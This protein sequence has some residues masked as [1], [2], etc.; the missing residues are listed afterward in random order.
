[1]RRDLPLG[2]TVE[3]YGTQVG[4]PGRVRHRR[5]GQLHRRGQAVESRERVT[6]TVRLR[7][8]WTFHD[9]TPVTA[10]SFV[11][12]WNCTAY[13]PNAQAGSYFFG[14]IEGYGDLQAPR[15]GEPTEP[16]AT[17]MSGLRSSTRR[18]SPSP[19]TAPFAQFPV[20]SATTRSSPCPRRSSRTRRRSAARRSATGRSRPTAS[21]SRR[22]RDGA[23]VR[24][25]G[26][27][28]PRRSRP[29]S[30]GSTP[31]PPPR[32][33]TRWPA[34]STSSR[35]SPPTRAVRPG[36]RFGDRYVET[37]ASG[38]TFLGLP[39]YDERY[40]DPRCVGP[41]PG[42]RPELIAETSSPVPGRRRTRSCRR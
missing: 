42:H 2:N 40:A 6:W 19:L 30:S 33:P 15:R 8:G 37:S 21:S 28:T 35:G 38:F 26:R 23:R 22:G 1:M 24:G 4:T 16:A 7:D 3:E 10:E 17:E 11:Y 39:L 18:P 12:A 20:T 34:T 27:A 29:S 25:R 5:R 32:T 36:G 41:V 14:N 9:G 13:S 31:T